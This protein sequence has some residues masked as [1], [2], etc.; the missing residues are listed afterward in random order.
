MS[1]IEDSTS[2][3]GNG[4]GT[5]TYGDI[6]CGLCG[7]KYNE[8]EDARGVYDGDSV[9]HADFAGLVVC[10]CCFDRVERGVL[11][12]MPDILVWYAKYL[13]RRRSALDGQ[14]KLVEDVVLALGKDPRE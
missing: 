11:A 13:R 3:F 7:G 10:D 1:R 4:M 9:S 14:D 12:W 5:G 6:T 2:L 8:G